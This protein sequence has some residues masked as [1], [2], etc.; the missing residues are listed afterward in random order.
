MISVN[1]AERFSQVPETFVDL[2]RDQTEKLQQTLLLLR[3]LLPQGLRSA[4][5]KRAL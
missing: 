3:L 2:E 4:L 1:V 5:N